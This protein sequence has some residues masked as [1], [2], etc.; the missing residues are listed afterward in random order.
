MIFMELPEFGDSQSVSPKKV[1][2]KINFSEFGGR[3]DSGKEWLA[4]GGG[5]FI[6][7]A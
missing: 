5:R 6:V 4:A 7:R 2:R 1:K 3:F